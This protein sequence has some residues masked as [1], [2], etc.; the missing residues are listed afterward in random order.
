MNLWKISRA[1]PV[2]AAVA[3]LA[4]AAP[5]VAQDSIEPEEP[6][7]R[8]ALT[9]MY[10]WFA[11]LSGTTAVGEFEIPVDSSFGDIFEVLEFAFMANLQVEYNRKFG[12]G[13]DFTYLKLGDV[14]NPD[15]PFEDLFS[16]S[17]EIETILAD[18]FGFYALGAPNP[19]GSFQVLGGTRIVSLDEALN[20]TAGD[21]EIEVPSI[22]E[23]SWADF[24]VGARYVGSPGKWTYGIR[25][26]LGGGGSNFTSNLSGVVA[27]QVISWLHIS[28][29]YRWLK[30]DY[31]NGEDP[32]SLRF[33]KYD[34]NQYGLLAG[35]TFTF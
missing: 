20:I 34:V 31:D 14:A 17:L 11:N 32:T 26:D 18:I 27:Y 25:Y 6:A 19:D 7:W 33:F 21:T 16:A 8:F 12:F 5:S 9:P 28:G 3:L 23:E 10:I 15:P 35:A 29:G 30:L 13:T 24:I 2:A 4:L 22:I 1:A